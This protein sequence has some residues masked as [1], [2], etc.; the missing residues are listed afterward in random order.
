MQPKQTAAEIE[1]WLVSH[2]AEMCELVAGEIDGQRPFTYY[3]LDSAKGV[4]LA[5]DLED[6]LGCS[7]SITL[8][9]EYPNIRSLAHFLAG[10]RAGP[11]LEQAAEA[12]L[13]GAHV[14]H[15]VR[16]IERLSEEEAQAALSIEGGSQ[17]PSDG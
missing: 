2:V 12:D 10:D 4:I 8:A 13:E 15:L 11:S 16:E 9:W 1:A 14:E 3:G 17:K 5:A 6:W 7:L